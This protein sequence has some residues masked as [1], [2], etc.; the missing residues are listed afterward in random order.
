MSSLSTS[1]NGDRMT[2]DF[3]IETVPLD[4]CLGGSEGL[5]DKEECFSK[6]THLQDTFET[7][8]REKGHMHVFTGMLIK[9]FKDLSKECS[10]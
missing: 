6:S 7:F 8:S 2:Q 10:L 9:I 4:C 3:G 5:R 1:D